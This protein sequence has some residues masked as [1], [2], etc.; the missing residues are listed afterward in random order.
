M[1]SNALEAQGMVIKHGDGASPEVFTT[2]PEVKSFSGPS[3][4]A[5]VIDVSDLSSTAKEKRMGLK[6]EGQVSLTIQ[7]IPQN[8]VHAAMRADRSNR[9]LRN[10]Q[11]D[12]TDSPTTTWQ[13][14]AYVL[15]FATSGSVDG[16]VEANVTLEISGDV[17]EV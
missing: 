1:S 14:S 9:T 8:A 12:F 3:G 7:Y 11:I 16:T 13:F 15:S 4:S 6:D 17:V 5:S 2:I 10:F